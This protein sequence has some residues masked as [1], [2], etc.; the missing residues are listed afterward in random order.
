MRNVTP[1]RQGRLIVVHNQGTNVKD[2]KNPF[3]ASLQ[4]K[5]Y[6]AKLKS[7]LKFTSSQLNGEAAL[8]RTKKMNEC[9]PVVQDNPKAT[10]TF[11]NDC[12]FMQHRPATNT[13]LHK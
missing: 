13:L 12:K 7:T 1:H 2:P 5:L 3:L 6:N 4:E 11:K 10:N 8:V 9:M